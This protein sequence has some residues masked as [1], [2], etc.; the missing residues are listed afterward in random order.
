M[1]CAK[2]GIGFWKPGAIIRKTILENY[3]V[4]GT[5]MIGMILIPQMLVD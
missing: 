1:V 3:A 2:Y 4:P 5:M